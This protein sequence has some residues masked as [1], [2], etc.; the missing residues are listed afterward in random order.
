MEINRKEVGSRIRKERILAD[1]S[2]QDLAERIGMSA[3]SVSN[4]EVGAR[5][6]SY[7]LL[8]KMSK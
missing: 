8:V 3:S 6:L 1:M 4:Y 5:E 7:D 2:R